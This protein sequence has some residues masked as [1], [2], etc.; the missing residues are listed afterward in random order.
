ME[1]Q[2]VLSP[3]ATKTATFHP[4]PRLPSELRIKIW[5]EFIPE[6][7][8]RLIWMRQPGW[9]MA[10]K[11]RFTSILLSACPESRDVYLKRF[12][13]GLE[14]NHREVSSDYWGHQWRTS[15]NWGGNVGTIYINPEQ[16]VLVLGQP[17]EGYGGFHSPSRED[18]TLL[19]KP[20]RREEPRRRIRNVIEF[21]GSEKL[22]DEFDI[23]FSE[24]QDE[25]EI[26]Y[27]EDGDYDPDD[28]P[29]NNL[30]GL[31]TVHWTFEG[32]TKRL[33]PTDPFDEDEASEFCDDAKNLSGREVLK[34]WEGKFTLS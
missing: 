31:P 20:L 27:S 28:T 21:P 30:W 1:T 12:P 13:M 6:T 25:Y 16:D 4:F 15:V 29:E 22:R 23:A 24:L 32:V 17:G 5:E 18:F 19:A 7:H 8:G 2:L 26:E 34:K 11:E 3:S 33:T 10:D 9:I 14:L